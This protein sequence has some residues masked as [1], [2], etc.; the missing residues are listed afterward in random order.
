VRRRWSRRRGAEAEPG[1]GPALPA[2][3]IEFPPAGESI[4]RTPLIIAGW[5]LGADGPPSEV[6]V[7]V[8]GRP[9]RARVGAAR[10]DDLVA[11]YPRTPGAEAA[12]WDA[13]VDVRGVAGPELTVT[14]VVRTG[15]GWTELD[16]RELRADLPAAS[17]DRRRAVF[18]IA[19]NEAAF[20][21]IWL[22]YYRRHF[23]PVDIYVLDNDTADGSTDGLEGTC[24]VVPVHRAESPEG[25]GASLLVWLVGTVEDF[26]AFLLRSYDAVLFAEVDELIVPDPRSYRGLGDYI[27]RL[28]GPAACCTGY[29]VV[30]DPDEE[31][32]LRFDEPILRQRRYWQLSPRW[33]SKRVLG[34]IPL[35]WNVG[36]H[37]EYNAPG[38][39]PD[40]EL[41]LIH[42]HRVD[43]EY[44]QA[45]HRASAS[46]EWPED[47]L[48]FN[49]SWHQRI[50]EP[51]EF[52]DWFFRGEDLEG[53]PREEI[54]E[55]IRE[56]V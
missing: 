40:P 24:N 11:A 38:V 7:F 17:G 54:P 2:G 31:P 12:G 48:R 1:R 32:P 45:R 26:Q 22:R 33:Y 13:I 30:H 9:T 4:P 46:R 25:G 14:L 37:D 27:D 52:R 53:T 47:D 44:C 36:F 19:R 16:R 55:R 34:R 35:S 50:A 10:R 56:V 43:Y 8:D 15:E 41:L 6:V 39:E 20:L 49:L 21:P 28:E 5:A 18:T 51:E 42:L 23:D 3:R 29:N